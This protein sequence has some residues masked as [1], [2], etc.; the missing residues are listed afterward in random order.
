MEK[1][2]VERAFELA[3]TGRFAGLKDLKKELRQEGYPEQALVGVV[4]RRDLQAACRA[5]QGRPPKNNHL[6]M[7][8]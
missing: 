6:R 7:S 5:A 4:L 2:L 3:R 1:T 8:E